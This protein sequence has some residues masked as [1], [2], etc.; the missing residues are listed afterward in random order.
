MKEN[1]HARRVKQILKPLAANNPVLERQLADAA[2]IYA[3]TTHSVQ[4]KHTPLIL[5]AANAVLLLQISRR[6]GAARALSFPVCHIFPLS[7]FFFLP[8]S[9]SLNF[10]IT[11]TRTTLQRHLKAKKMQ[12]PFWKKP[13][14]NKRRL[15]WCVYTLCQ[16]LRGRERERER[17]A[18]QEDADDGVCRCVCVCGER[19][20]QRDRATER[21]RTRERE[22]KYED[23]ELVCVDVVCMC[24]GGGG[25]GGEGGR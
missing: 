5:L 22:T 25:G 21:E 20:R 9:L 12:G 11:H 10:S 7:A 8:L 13:W 2:G 3:R 1:K 4:C 16:Y 14:P 19:E 6:A 17:E 18:G 24:V 15:S 23:A